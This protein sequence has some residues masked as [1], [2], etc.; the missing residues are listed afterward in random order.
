M[1]KVLIL[2]RNNSGISIMAIIAMI[3]TISAI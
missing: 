1:K 2:L 3:F